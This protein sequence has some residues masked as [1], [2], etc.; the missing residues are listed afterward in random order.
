MEDQINGGPV[1]VRLTLHKGF[2]AFAL[3]SAKIITT[4]GLGKGSGM[5]AGGTGI[6]GR[7]PGHC[8][9]SM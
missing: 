2:R 5:L 9:S 4:A 7:G 1:T 6:K 8:Y 3:I